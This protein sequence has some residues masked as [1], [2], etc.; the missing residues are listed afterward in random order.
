[1]GLL[2]TPHDKPKATGRFTTQV[3]LDR[4]AQWFWHVVN[5]EGRVVSEGREM[6][7][8]QAR[9][10]SSSAYTCHTQAVT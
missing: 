9:D 6:T 10:A 8:Q 4:S 5:P 3:W 7:E 1:M 2:Q